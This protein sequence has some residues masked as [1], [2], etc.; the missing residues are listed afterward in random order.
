MSFQVI[1]DSEA[2]SKGD[3]SD[4]SRKEKDNKRNGICM[5]SNGEDEEF[6]DMKKIVSPKRIGKTERG[7]WLEEI[8][9]PS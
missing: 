3:K 2:V 8:L 5:R 1:L 9:V 7:M 4:R 6:G